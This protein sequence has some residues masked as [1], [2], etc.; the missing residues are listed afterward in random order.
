MR[1]EAGP[2]PLAIA[3]RRAPSSL[4]AG[5]VPTLC[6]GDGDGASRLTA[7]ETPLP[8]LLD[9]YPGEFER[10]SLSGGRAGARPLPLRLPPR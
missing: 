4:T 9:Q 3:D 7:D 10:Q 1:P 2:G 8:S 5:R 6:G